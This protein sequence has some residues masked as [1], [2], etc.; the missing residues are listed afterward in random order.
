MRSNQ[1]VTL[2][3]TLA[4]LLL[5]C[6]LGLLLSPQALA[7]RPAISRLAISDLPVASGA[8]VST[9]AITV[10]Q[11]SGALRITVGLADTDSTLLVR[12]TDSSGS[13]VNLTLNNGTAL[14]AGN[15]YTFTV[16]CHSEWT[17]DFRVGTTTH[18]AY[19]VVDEVRDAAQ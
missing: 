2:A 12:A 13:P 6:G 19:L 4:A 5:F 14:T 9:S 3:G 7:G 11:D 10:K 15:V 1:R 8:D 18:L 17:Y 16:G